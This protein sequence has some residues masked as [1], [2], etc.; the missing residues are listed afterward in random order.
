M[1]APENVTAAEATVANLENRRK[2][3]II[4]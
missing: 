4:G 1:Y 3:A 2:E